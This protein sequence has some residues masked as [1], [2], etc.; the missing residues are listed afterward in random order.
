MLCR[1]AILPQTAI[2]AQ[3]IPVIDAIGRIGVLLNFSITQPARIA[4]CS[5]RYADE[6]PG[7]DRHTVQQW[8]Q[9]PAATACRNAASVTPFL[10][11]RMMALQDRRAGLPHFGLAQLIAFVSKCVDIVGMDLNGSARLASS[12]LIS[13]GICRASYAHWLRVP[14]RSMPSCCCKSISDMPAK[15]PLAIID[16]PSGWAAISQLSAMSVSGAVFGR[17]VVPDYAHPRCNPAV[18]GWKLVGK[19]G[20]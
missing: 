16:A 3:S 8:L 4:Y 2:T 11:P 17:K 10:K 20:S 1:H 18:P 6:I 7:F 9:F 15:G 13:G 14:I 19:A 12:S 5:R